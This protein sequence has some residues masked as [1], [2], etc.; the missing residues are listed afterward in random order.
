AKGILDT[1]VYSAPSQYRIPNCKGDQCVVENFEGTAGGRATLRKATENSYNT[2][3]AQV[4]QDVGVPEVGEMARKLGIT[5][6]WVASPEVHGV[7][8]ALGA[9]EV[10]PL[11]MASAYG[12]FATGGLRL[13]PTP[14]VSIRSADGKFT[15]DN[16]KR[17]PRRVVAEIIADNVTDVLKGVISGG[18]GTGANIGRPAAGK[19]GT[20]QEFGNA[21][22]IGFTPQLSTSVWIGDK[23]GNVPLRNVKG[24]ERVTGGSIPAAT[25]KAY[26]TEALKD[27]APTEFHTPLPLESTSTTSSTVFD[28]NLYTIPPETST[29][30]PFDSTSTLPPETTT[31]TE[32]TTTT[33][34]RRGLLPF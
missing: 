2:V 3:Y 1:K 30:V 13:E 31:T 23:T 8:Y 6:A 15:V 17:K 24:L 34:R 28:P 32:P 18:T 5:S 9:Q 21:W 16:R 26:M 29:T 22:F 14:I 33:T 27:V 12:V 19:T 20:S 10:S 11:D 4:I 25:W 7:S